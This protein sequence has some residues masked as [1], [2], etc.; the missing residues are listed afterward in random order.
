[1]NER[2]N[3]ELGGANWEYSFAPPK[4]IAALEG[5]LH[6]LWS[7]L[8]AEA[9]VALGL[10]SDGVVEGFASANGSGLAANNPI[11]LPIGRG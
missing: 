8:A 2:N 9:R 3:Y 5:L 7:L 6:L 1:M 4:Q 10:R 11:F